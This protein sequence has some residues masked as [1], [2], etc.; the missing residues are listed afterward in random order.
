MD[1]NDIT[2]TDAE[3]HVISADANY[4]LS[5]T[6]TIQVNKAKLI[7]DTAGNTREYGQAAEVASDI[8]G[9]A[10]IR[11]ADTAVVNGDTAA[12]QPCGIL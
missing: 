8:A 3:G 7:I 10:S 2:I 11:H 4:D 9:A 6:G 5:T 1:F 12:D